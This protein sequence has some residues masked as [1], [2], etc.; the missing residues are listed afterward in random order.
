MANKAVAKVCPVCGQTAQVSIPVES[1]DK[2]RTGTLLQK[3]W[4]EG[5]ATERETLISGLCPRCQ[6]GVFG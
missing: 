4:P 5:S 1:Y 6:E 3:A 2:W